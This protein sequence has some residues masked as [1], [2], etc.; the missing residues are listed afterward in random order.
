VLAAMLVLIP[1]V[2]RVDGADGVR[3]TLAAIDDACAWWP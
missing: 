1:V 2:A 3:T